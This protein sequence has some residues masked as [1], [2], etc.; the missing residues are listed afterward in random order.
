MKDDLKTDQLTIVPGD[1]RNDFN[2]QACV[3][4]FDPEAY[5]HH[6]AEYDLTDDQKL[7]VMRAL[8][9]IL[10]CFSDAGFKIDPVSLAEHTQPDAAQARSHEHTEQ[11]QTKERSP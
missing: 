9:D 2:D 11:Q 8:W 10:V 5:A 3:I 7:T 4:G 6:L 1:C